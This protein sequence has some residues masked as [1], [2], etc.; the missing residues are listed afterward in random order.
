MKK[1]VGL[2]V[3]LF[4]AGLSFGQQDPVVLTVDGQKIHKSEFL[5]SYLKNNN[6]PKYDKATLNEYVERYSNFKMKVAEAEDLG[7]DTI[8]TLVK[9]LKGYEKQ[10]ALPY[11]VDSAKNEMLVKEAY[12]RLQKEIRAS[13]ILIRVDENAKPA[14]TLKAYQR[15]MNL[16]DRIKAGE[17]FE[18]LARSKGGSE[19][20]S[21]SQNGGDLGYFTAFQMVYP[22]ET[23][24]YTTPVGKVSMPVRTKY[25]YHILKVTDLRD[26]RGTMTAAHIL[27]LTTGDVKAQELKGA[28]NKIDSIY[29]KLEAGESWIE[30]TRKYS[31]DASSRNKGGILPDFGSGTKQRMVP[32]FED[33]AFALTKDGEYS[34]PF[35]S[36]YGYHIVKR[37]TWKPLPSYEEMEKELYNKVNRDIRGQKTQASFIAKIKKQYNYEL[38][39]PA[40]DLLQ[41]DLDSSVFSGKW[42]YKGSNADKTIFKYAG[43]DYKLAEFIQF[44]DKTLRKQPVRN[45]EVLM[46]ELYTAWEKQQVIGYEES[47][48]KT[49]YPAY[50][51]LMQE[52]HDGILLY[53]IMKDKVWE[54]ASKDTTGLN[55]F[56][57]TNKAQYMHPFRLDAEIYE[58]YNKKDAKKVYKLAKKGADIAKLEEVFGGESELRLRVDSSI[59]VP[60]KDE[61]LKDQNLKTGVNKPFMLN[62]KYY[63][64]LVNKEMP[65]GPK[66]LKEARGA[67]IQDYQTQLEE[68]WLKELKAK[69]EVVINKDVLYSLGS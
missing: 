7:Y 21:V 35:K 66:T 64:V 26:A 44:L 1:I 56:Y 33:E 49:K 43:R 59:V 48:L 18:K 41:A 29:A 34:K 13:H 31:D 40:Y 3:S 4:L 5:Q 55:K 2:S 27:V 61:R 37:I 9:E 32:I 65:E 39:T 16:R 25:G 14:D 10:L 12:D 45:I 50:K 57:E 8:P 30:L 69:H 36:Q 46:D 58:V 20:P 15:I 62:D 17:D 22:F 28:K 38:I 60:Q 6:A 67:V 11:L 52:Y 19:D 47:L 42:E 63:V 53:E 23:A 24:A 54:K 51:A 68:N